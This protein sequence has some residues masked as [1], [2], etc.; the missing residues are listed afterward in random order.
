M[1]TYMCISISKYMH[2]FLRN[3]TLKCFENSRLTGQCTLYGTSVKTKKK[4]EQKQTG[5]NAERS[6]ITH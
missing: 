2:A 3:M 1:V 4:E 5:A 6:E